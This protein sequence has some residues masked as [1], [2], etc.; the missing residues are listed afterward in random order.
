M[1]STPFSTDDASTTKTSP[2]T[3]TTTLSIPHFTPPKGCLD[4]T[5]IWYLEGEC[6]IKQTSGGNGQSCDFFALDPPQTCFPESLHAATR[7][8]EYYTAVDTRD[9]EVTA[10]GG[11]VMTSRG[12]K[13]CPTTY[14]FHDREATF[15]DHGGNAALP[16]ES[17]CI[18]SSPSFNGRA[19]W[20]LAVSEWTQLSF[21]STT[22]RTHV[23]KT[24][25]FDPRTDTLLASPVT[26]SFVIDADGKTCAPDCDNP[27][28]G[29]QW[30]M[31]KPRQD[32]YSGL[33]GVLISIIVPS[34]L[35]GLII[36]GCG[37][38]W[39]VRSRRNKKRMERLAAWELAR[40]GQK[41]PGELPVADGRG[42][43]TGD[44]V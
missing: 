2:A 1:A 9:M 43:S 11:G 17:N 41:G 36:V 34:V 40:R 39:W 23:P 21:S 12:I 28:T 7:C 18:A 30:P 26:I 44:K 8:P 24:R 4:P 10:I 38:G 37:C 32:E 15:T 5:H 22:G 42:T 20:T 14:D 33:P 13:C 6:S 35:G 3:H 19:P 29:G 31:P 27:Y 25:E 16:W